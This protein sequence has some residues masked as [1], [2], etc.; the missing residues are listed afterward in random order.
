MYRINLTAV[1]SI[2]ENFLN[3]GIAEYKKRL[4]SMCKFTVTEVEEYKL[5]DEG[6]S[7][8]KKALESE[9]KAILKKMEGC[10]N[11]L[12][13]IGGKAVSSEELSGIVVKEAQLK[14]VN[15]IIGSSYGVCDEVRKNADYRISF[16]RITMPHRLFRL[17]LSEQIYR[18]L[19]IAANKNYHK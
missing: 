9:G 15:F 13:D 4:S 8:V 7:S 17:V 16:G 10:C 19:A 6:A 14:E 12:M 11:I 1:G 2:K 5:T 18:S 3:E